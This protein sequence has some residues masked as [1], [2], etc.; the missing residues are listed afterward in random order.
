MKSWMGVGC[1]ILGVIF[2]GPGF[3]DGRGPA[4]VNIDQKISIHADDITLIELFRLWDQATGMHSTVPLDLEGLKLSVRFTGLEVNDALR[5]IA[6]GQQFG[7]ILAADQVILTPREPVESA[8][9]PES[10]G[11][12]LPPTDNE[13]SGEANESSVAQVQRLKPEPLPPPEPTY[14]PTPFGPIVSPS[15]NRPFVQLPPVDVAPPPPFFAP[16]YPPPPPAGT[17][18]GPVQNNL[19]GPLPVYRDSSLP[20]VNSQPMR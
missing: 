2:A 16:E 19:F 15:W 3:A 1:I 18:N 13:I 9:S 7:Y 12:L 4:V 11:T 10:D 8:T 17:P 20:P 6:D 5:R 14:I